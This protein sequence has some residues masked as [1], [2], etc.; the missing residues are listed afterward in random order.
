[1]SGAADAASAFPSSVRFLAALAILFLLSE[2]LEATRG[3]RAPEPVP[4]DLPP[5]RL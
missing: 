1:M 2:L 5:S 3:N 4:L